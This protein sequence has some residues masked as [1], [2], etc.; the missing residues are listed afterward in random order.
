MYKNGKEI[1]E[2]IYNNT[3]YKIDLMI[4]EEKRMKR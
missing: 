2:S 1:K 3:S 4:K